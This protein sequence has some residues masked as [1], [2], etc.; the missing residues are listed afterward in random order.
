MKRLLIIFIF[1]SYSTFTYSQAPNWQ[2][3]QNYVYNSFFD[4][5]DDPELP[6]WHPGLIYRGIGQLI[7][8]SL[9][10]RVQNGQLELTM[11][12][13]HG[14]ND[15]ANYVGAEF[16][17]N[18]D[19]SFGIFECKAS[20]AQGLGSWPAFWAFF[21]GCVNNEGPEIDFAEY[22]GRYVYATSN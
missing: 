16:V 10:H 6:G 3:D 18:K 1:I 9:T 14:Y 19:F 8:S 4:D 7:D 13:I 20:F 15:S 2:I 11:A 12:H 5:F 22:F 17:T 21:S